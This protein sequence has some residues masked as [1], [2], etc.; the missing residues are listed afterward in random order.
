[1]RHHT[2]LIVLV[3]A[4]VL[5]S[6]PALAQ[7]AQQ[8]PKLVGTGATGPAEQGRSVSLSADGNT[9][10]IGGPGDNG[11]A[12]AAWVLTKIGGVWT[13]QGTKLVGSGAIVSPNGSAQGGAVS[14][15]ADGNTAIVGVELDNGSVGAA[16]IWTRNGGVWTQQGAKLVGSGAV[17]A[18]HQGGSVSLSADGNTAIIGG[19]QDDNTNLHGAAWVW[20]RSGGV[21]TQ[22]GPKLFGSGAVGAFDG[23]GS[24]VSISADGNTA[25]IGAQFDDGDAGAAWVWTR[26]GGVWS[27]QGTKLVGSG[28]FGRLVHQGSAVAISGDGNTVIVGGPTDDGQTGAMWVWTR[29]GGVWTQQ[30]TKLVGSGASGGFVH[31]GSAVSLS[32]DGNTAIVGGFWDNDAAGAAWVWTRSGGVWTQQGSKLVGSGAVG[33]AYQG[34]SVSLS[35]DGNTA[36]VGGASDNGGAGAAWVWGSPNLA[37]ATPSIK[38]AGIV[39]ASAFGQFPSIAPGS[40]IE[41]YGSNLA[42]NSRSWTG[43]DFNGS[44]AP[45]SLDGTRVTIGGQPAFIAY[46][47]PGQINALVPST[48]GT[49]PVVV[50][51]PVGS[52]PPYTIKVNQ[53]QAGLLA[54][55]SFSIG[56]KQNV[57]AVFSDGATFVLPTGAIAGVNSRP[58][59][60]GDVI[61]LYGIGFGEV[62]PGIPVG[63]IAQISNALVSPIHLMFGQ[64]EATVSYAG[65]AP[66]AVGLYQFNAVV[67]NVAASDVVPVTFTVGGVSGMQ[68]LY[69]AVTGSTASTQV[70]GLTLS[71][72]S[73]SGGG[74]VQ[75]TVS[76]S[77]PAPSGGVIVALS[78][79]APAATVPATV[80]VSAASTSATFTV[81]TTAVSSTQSVAIKATYNGTSAQSTLTVIPPAT[82]QVQTLSLSNTSITGG[83][84]VQGT[85]VLSSPAPLGGTVVALSSSGPSAS[86]P[87]T[88]TVSAASTS[89]TFTV[90]TTTVSSTQ[91]VAIKATYGGTSAQSNLAVTPAATAQVGTISTVAGNGIWGFSGDG[92]SATSASLSPPTGVAVDSAG[93][94]Y[95][96]DC[97]NNRIR[98]VTPSGMISTV[99]GNGS[100]GFS[101]DGG[102][103]TS[104][105]L[106]LSSSI[107]LSALNGLAVDSADNLYISD[108]FNN[109]IRKVTPGGVI[110]T[111]AGNGSDGFGGDGGLASAA[112]LSLPFAVAVD[113]TGN[114]Y[115]A[116][117]GNSRIRKV[118][119]GG[120]ISTV[121]GSGIEGYSDDGGLATSAALYLPLGI[122]LDGAGNLYIS[123][124]L[125]NRVRKVTPGGVIS[126]VPVSGYFSGPSGLAVDSGGNLYIACP[127]FNVIHRVAPNGS[128]SIVAGDVTRM[129]FDGDGGPATAASLLYPNAVAVDSAGNLYISDYGNLRIRRVQLAP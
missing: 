119:P 18:A 71:N 21:W 36:I 57:V 67:P 5:S 46:I 104:A 117:S 89:A 96:A 95:I 56:G 14:V 82:P 54:P 87:A 128:A 120:V 51:T 33:K 7:F 28:A 19:P 10:I 11:G 94:L 76:L 73:I 6:H 9:A 92:G 118:T 110:S 101:G 31:Q 22:Q 60:P 121:A 2:E 59:Q 75:G 52:S 91:S 115:I 64:T 58:A 44:T 32:G 125:T 77:S 69:I 29:I 113:R 126:T 127:E 49:Q 27:Q 42:T 25:I 93:N 62:T 124:S 40:W 15:S 80:I 43:A 66:S 79:S 111:V 65:L 8:G 26:S 114:L 88:V 72:T 109:R 17:G 20:T 107:T 85:V 112:S 41:I 102:S 38:S 86:V 3:C 23:Q 24:S 47:S 61:T 103:A 83:L 116:D 30:G 98:K 100:A 90:S 16:W 108:S 39:S 35:A 97:G 63:Q 129:G 105:R 53:L 84:S 13:Q 74:S 55:Q 45:T 37:P 78:S 50:V 48:F 122:A 99:A 1:M 106:Y 4:I 123:D 34:V 68:T 70:R 12:G 81:S